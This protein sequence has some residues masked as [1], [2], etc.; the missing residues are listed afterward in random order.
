M[1][2]LSQGLRCYLN[3]SLFELVI[4][5]AN[6]ILQIVSQDEALYICCVHLYSCILLQNSSTMKILRKRGIDIVYIACLACFCIKVKQNSVPFQC[7]GY[8]L[9]KTMYLLAEAD[10]GLIPPFLNLEL[11]FMSR[12][13]I[14]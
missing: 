11:Y 7:L 6:V 14:K 2:I 1:I 4:S 3:I 8:N 10:Y 12:I 9:K 13:F 5:M